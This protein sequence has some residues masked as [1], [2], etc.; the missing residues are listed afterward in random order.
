MIKS[1]TGYGRGRVL[2]DGLD[3]TFEIKSVNNRYMDLNI[4]MP[5]AFAPL[6]ELSLIHI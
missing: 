6:E 4:R 3:I 1:M 2:A 5:R